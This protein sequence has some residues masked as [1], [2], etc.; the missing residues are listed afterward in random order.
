MRAEVVPFPRGAAEGLPVLA[1]SGQGGF[2]AEQA[3]EHLAGYGTGLWAAWLRDVVWGSPEVVAFLRAVDQ[4]GHLVVG[5]RRLGETDWPS[6]GA[7]WILDA[8]EALLEGTDAD[9][10]AG[11]LSAR[12]T[13]F[14]VV[15]DL[16][17][18]LRVEQHPPASHLLDMLVDAVRPSE[19]CYIYAP[20][21]YPFGG[22][23]LRHVIQSSTP[24]AIRGLP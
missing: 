1:L 5:L 23:L 6:R 17:V 24:W 14:P 7:A 15:N 19:G 3:L 2:E 8:S 22:L 11:Y 18:D 10:L 12:A 16:V 21:R 13:S 9:A 20:P 4:R